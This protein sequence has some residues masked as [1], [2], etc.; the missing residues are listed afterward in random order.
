M[1]SLTEHKGI[2]ESLQEYARHNQFGVVSTPVPNI[3]VCEGQFVVY[4]HNDDICLRTHD[5]AHALVAAEVVPDEGI[6]L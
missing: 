5:A 3:I 4:D 1:P 2:L 6:D